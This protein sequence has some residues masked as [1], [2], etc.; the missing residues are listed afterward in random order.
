VALRRAVGRWP[1]ATD[2]AFTLGILALLGNR[3]PISLRVF[4][5]ALAVIDDVLSVLTLAIFYVSAFEIYWL[6]ISVA[7][8]ALLY[9]LNGA[10]VYAAW[11]YV[12]VAVALGFS[13][14]GAGVHAA[15]A[16]VILAAFLPTRPA[17]DVGPLLGQA[18]TALAALEYEENEAKKAGGEARRI[19][20]EPIWDWASRNLSAA[21]DRLLS[22]ADRIERAVAPW[23]AYVILPLFA[24]S[25]TG[26]S[27]NVNLSAPDALPILLGVQLGLV[28]GKP[29]GICIASWIAVVTR[30]GTAPEDVTIRQFIGAACL[31]GCRRYRCFADRGSSLPGKRRCR[32]RKDR[33]ADR[34]CSGRGARHA[35]PCTWPGD[36]HLAR[37]AGQLSLEFLRPGPEFDLPCPGGARL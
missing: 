11:P 37:I 18:A 6:L 22:P 19:D 8:A 21:S 16:G 25:A 27:F 28:I 13:L 31:C 35:H 12:V 4:V 17:P 32:R 34:F 36:H 33:R 15:L 1:T 23:S 3:I 24:F 26:V 10:R 14:H 5:A 2:I 29:L 30:A 20:Q 7:A 9:G